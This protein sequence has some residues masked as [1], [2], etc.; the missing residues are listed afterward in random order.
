M[1][2]QYRSR[3]TLDEYRL[4]SLERSAESTRAKGFA[5]AMKSSDPLLSAWV[6]TLARK[7]D[8]PAIFATSGEVLRT[9][10][11]IEE[12]TRVLLK[13]ID[14]VREADVLA[15][16]IGNHEDWPSIFIACLSRHLVVLPLEQ[17]ISQQQRDEALE[18]CRAR[19]V[20]S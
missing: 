3:N 16:Q 13:K 11:E 14:V 12:R 9:F 5:Q 20:M 6:K 8:A 15:V 18:I 2:T 4:S 19:A 7:R 1:R 17:S 10:G